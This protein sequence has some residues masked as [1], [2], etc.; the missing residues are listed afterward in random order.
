[1]SPSP[2]VIGFT[3]QLPHRDRRPG[4]RG[5]AMTPEPGHGRKSL[6]TLMML[7][8]RTGRSRWQAVV[9]IFAVVAIATLMVTATHTGS[10]LYASPLT[11]TVTA[12]TLLIPSAAANSLSSGLDSTATS[13]LPDSTAV[14]AD[15]LKAGSPGM[16]GKSDGQSSSGG[17]SSSVNNPPPGGGGTAPVASTATSGTIT[18]GDSKA[19]CITLRFPGG[20]LTPSMVSAVTDLTGVTYNC[21]STFANPMPTWSDWE[22][23]WMFATVSDGWGAWLAGRHPHPAIVG[24]DLTPQSVSNNKNPLTW[25][26]AC[27]AGSY[28]THAT[29]LAQNLVSYGA[30]KVVIRF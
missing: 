9:G 24:I 7:G 25:E 11:G 10:K 17:N 12:K 22:Q 15:P 29:K 6:P 19:N 3:T 8:H 16:A 30:G 28:D 5:V 4:S 26:Q 13:S 1:M 14:V 18:A 27:A 20:V 21:L 2:P 23:P